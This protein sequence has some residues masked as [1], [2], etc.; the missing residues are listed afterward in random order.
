MAIGP[1][2]IEQLEDLRGLSSGQLKGMLGT[3]SP[4]ASP[5]F[6]A[7]VLKEREDAEKRHAGRK[8]AAQ[9]A[10]QAPTVMHRLQQPMPMSQAGAMAA[11]PQQ[12][13]MP[14]ASQIAMALS[15]ATGRPPPELPTVNM[16]R[17]STG[18]AMREMAKALR[19]E[20]TRSY[21]Q[22]RGINHFLPVN[23]LLP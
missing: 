6:I 3:P 18:A 13:P 11:P 23:G 5:V 4:H 14:Q 19:G 22:R 1:S 21:A 10:G 15:G 20:G 9:E 7:M 2:M 8:A 12:P 16:Q 17:G